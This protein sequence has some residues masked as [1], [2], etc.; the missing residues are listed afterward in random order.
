MKYVIYLRVS[1]KKQDKD[2]QLQMCMEFLRKNVGTQFEFI[3]YF[4]E[5]TSKKPLHKREGMR[6]ALHAIDR[7]DVLVGQRVDRLA[8]HSYETHFIKTLLD[9][10]GAELMLTE[11]PGI[12]NKVIFGTYIGI[13]EEEGNLIRERTRNK[14]A[15]KKN[16]G[17]RTGTVLFGYDLDQINLIL[18]N[19]PDQTKVLKPGLLIPNVLEQEQLGVM[20]QLFDEGLS[21]RQITHTLNNRGYRN[22]EGNP[23][24][25]NSIY[26]IVSRTGRKRSSDQ[27]PQES[28]MKMLRLLSREFLG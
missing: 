2:T 20:C 24:Q 10:K 6:Q 11:Q 15:A 27:P 17:E 3:V 1:T 22:R 12:K 18:V 7:G 13:A 14:L 26:R 9:A 25:H 8:R 28:D 4:D 19:G 23:F 21:F 16:K 5:I